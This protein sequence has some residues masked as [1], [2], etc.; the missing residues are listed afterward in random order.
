[1]NYWLINHSWESFRRTQE[2]C[3]FM[4]E[5][6]RDKIKVGDKI[7]YYGQGLVF[8]IFE[9]ASLVENEFNG[10]GKKY[11]FQVKFQPLPIPNN[12]TKQGLVAKGL[13]GKIFLTKAGGGSP[14][15]VE[16]NE[17]EFNKVKQAVS[18]GKKQVVFD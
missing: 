12:P 18:E 15:L 8:G 14:N 9:A 7:V 11:P 6:E 5:A 4:V 13:Q 10:W 17:Y 3:G 2:Y 1:M 16:L